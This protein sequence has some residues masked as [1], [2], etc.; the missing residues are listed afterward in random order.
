MYDKTQ[1][2]ICRTE[3]HLPLTNK[4]NPLIGRESGPLGI[5]DAPHRHGD[6]TVNYPH[7]GNHSNKIHKSPLARSYV[8]MHKIAKLPVLVFPLRLRVNYQAPVNFQAPSVSQHM[9]YK[10]IHAGISPSEFWFLSQI[11]DSLFVNI[12]FFSL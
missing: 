7:K 9:V 3:K 5:E 1:N 2:K 12:I 11:I 4:Q 10:Y 6:S 8:P